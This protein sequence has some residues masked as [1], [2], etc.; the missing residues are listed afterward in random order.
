MKDLTAER[1]AAAATPVQPA[2]GRRILLTTLGS[3][4]DLHPY[5]ALARALQAR[6]HSVVLAT[7][8]VYREK[9]EALGIDFAA[10]RPD[11][12]DPES[13]PDLIRR[14]MDPWRGTTVVWREFILPAL[15]DS[16]ED[17]RAAA[18]GADLLVS[19]PLTLTTRLAAEKLGI[20]WASTCLAPLSFLS[21]YEPPVL[22]QVPS[23]AR[24]RPLG[25]GFHRVLLGFMKWTIRSWARSW[26]ALRAELGLPPAHNPLLEGQHSPH[27]VAAMFSQVLGRP[28]P[29]WPASAR[30]TGFAFFDEDG[31]PG[32]DPELTRFL[33]AG[34]PPVVFTLGSSAVYVPGSFYRASA[35]AAARLGR[36]AVLVVG[37]QP[38]NMPAAGSLPPGVLAV[39]Y[40]PYSELFPRAAAVVHQ[41]GVG[42]TAQA[43]RGGR[44]MLVVP[45][46]H[47]QPDNADRVR[48]LGVARVLPPGG[49]GPSRAAGALRALLEDPGCAA[50]AA[51]VG[52]RVR[53]EDGAGAAADALDRLVHKG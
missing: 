13:H 2:R 33:D 49:Y 30:V 42:T 41:G 22:P 4:G 43:L 19:H 23:L 32:L 39:P 12:P 8:A 15:R 1:P 11:L 16:Y 48:R 31:A 20:P 7:S 21:A 53:A 47:D 27:L 38:R 3:L 29:D 46:A 14:I 18:A 51:E 25:P 36:R 44:P 37:R 9:V 5:I 17:T 10:L 45:F 35:A 52:R 26:H 6:G 40:A 50:R 28:Q 34:P 24:L